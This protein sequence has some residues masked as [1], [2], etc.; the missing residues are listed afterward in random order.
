MSNKALILSM[1]FVALFIVL[2]NYYT[3]QGNTGMPRPD[4]ITGPSY[5]YAVLGLTADFTGGFT[6]V[7]AVGL[8]L[9][10][11]YRV[12]QGGSSSIVKTNPGSA[13]TRLTKSGLKIP[14]AKVGK[15][16]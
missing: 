5:L 4:V 8:T 2:R 6:T 12:H 7:L 10:L 3:K 15:K 14:N 16:K 9:G 1:Y 11:Y 13:R